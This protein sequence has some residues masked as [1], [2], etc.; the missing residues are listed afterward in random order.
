MSIYNITNYIKIL[1]IKYRPQTPIAKR[2][3][4]V[5]L[6]MLTCLLFWLHGYGAGQYA[7]NTSPIEYMAFDDELVIP[8]DVEEA[9]A[10]N[11]ILVL[12]L[13]NKVIASNNTAEISTKLQN[14]STK[15]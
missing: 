11:D 2:L 12:E 9:E 10:G 1:A 3:V 7:A 13:S 5:F 6:I 4:W 15:P 14:F 8:H